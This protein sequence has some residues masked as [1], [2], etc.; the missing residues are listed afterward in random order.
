M[1]HLIPPGEENL[2]IESEDC[3]CNPEFSV[4]EKS[5]EMIYTHLPLDVEIEMFPDHLEMNW[6]M[7][8]M[9]L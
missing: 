4:D 2:H 8:L 5:G 1:I 9:P 6:G 3:E 7:W